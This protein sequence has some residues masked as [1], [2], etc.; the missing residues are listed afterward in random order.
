[1]PLRIAP[2]DAQL[3]IKKIAAD[4]KTRKHLQEMGIVVGGKITLL[5]A[6][7]NGVILVVKEGRLCLDGALASK[8][9]VSVA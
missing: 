4:D 3:E 8:I 1:M 6:G 5:S 9:I 2:K 7:T